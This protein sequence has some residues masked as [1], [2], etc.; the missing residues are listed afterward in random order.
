MVAFKEYKDKKKE[1]LGK[2]P[3]SHENREN[4]DFEKQKPIL[5][6]DFTKEEVEQLKQKPKSRKQKRCAIA[7]KSK[8]IK[9]KKRQEENEEKK[10]KLCEQL[11][12]LN[13]EISVIKNKKKSLA[14]MSDTILKQNKLFIAKRTVV[15]CLQQFNLFKL[16][17]G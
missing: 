5:I 11:Q 6:D 14:K 10:K 13:K 1:E 17:L 16:L 4:V 15:S 7:E 3:K 2:D 12:V 9:Q 8:E